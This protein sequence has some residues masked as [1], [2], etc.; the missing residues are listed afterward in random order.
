MGVAQAAARQPLRLLPAGF[1]ADAD[2][3]TRGVDVVERRAQE[4]QEAWVPPTFFTP[5]ADDDLMEE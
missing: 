3:P 1:E 2:H 4:P 5:V